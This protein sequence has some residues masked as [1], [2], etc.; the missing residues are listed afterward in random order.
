MKF[1]VLILL[2]TPLMGLEASETAVLTEG[3]I[4]EQLERTPPT[5]QQI[6]A[7]FLQ[8]Q[9]D[10]AASKDKYSYRLEA[11]GSKTTSKEKSL[12]QF[13]PVVSSASSY[14]V[15][16]VKPTKYGIKLGA[17][18]F[19]R[20]SSNNLLSDGASVGFSFSMTMDLYRNFLGKNSK[21]SLD[22]NGLSVE[23]AKLEKKVS[24]KTFESNLRK[25]YW[26]L[27]ANAESIRVTKELLNLSKK[28]LQDSLKRQKS[29]V[30]DAGE[31]ARYYSQV[32]SRSSSVLSLKYHR[33]EI[34]RSIKELL[35]E[36]ANKKV[37]LGSYNVEEAIVSVL[38]CSARIASQPSAPLQ[39]TPYDEIVKVIDQEEALEIG[40][41]NTYDSADLS[42]TSEFNTTGK[43][44]GYGNAIE[45]F[46][47]NGKPSVNIGLKLVIPFGS[48]K[49]TTQDLRKK[50]IRKRA[51]AVNSERIGKVEA[52]HTQTAEAIILL[53]QVVMNQ[54]ANSQ[55]LSKS[56]AETKK[57]YSQ[58]RATVQELVIEQDTLLQSSLDEIQTNLTV[59]NTL[60]DY[61]SIYT[62]TP[63][64][65]N[66][67]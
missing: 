65:L 57:K 23:R 25:I 46:T 16:I 8:T 47:A 24:L 9:A 18:T 33:A 19:G 67:I 41:E 11:E 52:F 64:D 10:L 53:N 39:Y 22:K 49:S 14:S 38:A 63:C 60:L 1:K 50:V 54:K 35:P 2:F 32:S 5:V 34:I 48:K 40:I 58:A 4:R 26:S 55:Y 61:F 15:G 13:I 59:M 56:V 12:N 27:V 3:L 30:A 43:D 28:Q 66:R 21:A 17:G 51:R 42:L 6:E 37:E 29:S 20:K 45:D 44:F 36:L 31:V 7:S 62:E